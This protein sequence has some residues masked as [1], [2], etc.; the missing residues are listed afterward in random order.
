[1]KWW[2]WK[3]FFIVKNILVLI[4]LL[5]GFLFRIVFQLLLIIICT[6]RMWIGKVKHLTWRRGYEDFLGL[7]FWVCGL[8]GG[9]G[10]K[11]GEVK[12]S[13]VKTVNKTMGLITWAGLALFAKIS[14]PWLNATKTQLWDYMTT[15]PAQLA[16]IALLETLRYTVSM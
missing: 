2:L 16:G 7:K 6:E 10:W 4:L 14:A 12:G 8:G 15:E 1:M 9:G 11:I 5:L 3:V 13:G